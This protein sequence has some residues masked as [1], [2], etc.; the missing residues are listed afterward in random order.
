MNKPFV[1][2]LR[3]IVILMGLSLVILSTTSLTAQDKPQFDNAVG[4]LPPEAFTQPPPP[5]KIE[6]VTTDDGFD[7]FFLGLDFAEPHM[8]SNPMNPLEY[9]N[10]WNTNNSHYTYDGHDW[11]TQAPPFPGYSMRG[12]PVTAYDSLGNLY[13][14]NMYGSPSIQGAMVI[15][16]TDNGAT[17]GPPVA[18]VS[19]VDKCW[20]AC[21]QTAGP[22][23]NFVYAVMT[24]SGGG[25][26]ARSTDFGGTWQ[27]TQ[28]FATQSL[29]GM[30]VAVGPDVLGGNDIS[31]GC[32]YVVTNGGNTFAP[33]YTFYRSTDGGSTFT[34]MSSQFFA[35]YVGTN[36]SGRHSVENMRTRPYPF[37]AADNSRGPYRGRLYCVYASNT[38]V[39]NGNKPDIFVQFSDD[40]GFSWSGPILINDDPNTT[41][42]HQWS[43]SIWCDKETGRFYAKWYDS[44]N[45]PTSDSCDVYASYSD[46]GG[47][48]WTPNV[49]LTNA[50]MVIDCA[51]CPGGGTPR[52]QGDYDAITSNAYGAMAVWTDFRAGNFGSY[53]AYF[54]DFAMKIS[55]ASD[56]IGVTDSIEVVVKI[57]AVKLYEH[58]IK[59][60]V[61]SEPFGNFIYH[62]PQGDSLTAY[63]DSV[64]L[65]VQADSVMPGDY[66]IIVQAKGPNGTPVHRRTI[67]LLV[68]EPF[69]TMLQPNG[70]EELYAGTKYGIRWELALV[71]SVN[72]DYS[73]D[74][75]MTWI[76]ITS[77]LNKNDNKKPTPHPKSRLKPLSAETIESALN[78]YEWVVPTT[79]SSNCLVRVSSS[80][81]ST[82]FDISDGTFSIIP[83][84][85]PRWS[86]QDPGIDTALYS[87]SVVDTSIVWIAGANGT[88]IRSFDGGKSWTPTPLPSGE[89]IFNIFAVNQTRIFMAVN[90][91]GS[92]K[93]M[94]TF[95]G[96][97]TWQMVYENTN[98]N[99]F[100][101]AVHM[102]DILNGYALG[103]PINGQWTLL[104]TI[105]GGFSWSSAG[106]L[107]QS[108]QETGY[109]N[110]FTWI[111]DQFGWFGTDNSQ[112][113]RTT[114]GGTDWSPA[115]TSFTNSFSV[116]FAT[117]ML[118]LASGEATDQSQDGGATWTATSAQLPTVSF[119]TVAL[120]LDPPRWY[121]I[122]GSEVYKTTDQGDTFSLEISQPNTFFDIDMKIVPLNENRWLVGYA[123]GNMGTI[124]RYRE[125]LDVTIVTN[126]N[127]SK[128]PARFSLSQNY[129]NPFNPTTTISYRLPVNAEVTIHIVNV[130]GQEVR[131][132]ESG[133]KNAGSYEV[134]WDGRNSIG[135]PVASGIY[136]YHLVAKPN[137]GK[138]YSS[139]KKMMILK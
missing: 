26:F 119:G 120:D 30:M 49:R 35:N 80:V 23:A 125:L 129:P 131:L 48:T 97:S 84:P 127:E 11:E 21:D 45:V 50:R 137:S 2:V 70:G 111:G 62:F 19:G 123:V 92:A 17:W 114:N 44:R 110:A 66:D 107:A 82:F 73:L 124:S 53:T 81:D 85:L 61:N 74:S 96:G 86:V 32:V 43:P 64:L 109:N 98:A 130:L 60:S 1:T 139:F 118:G 55:T 71:D 15:R 40:Q 136:F 34:L 57:P 121:S 133:S 89:D 104:R 113:Y 29:P 102:F 38:P 138:E 91:P 88:V 117:E 5:S 67:S 72:L 4:V 126:I 112:I 134:T 75:G 108:G 63:P 95:N 12:D 94:R 135:L 128:V 47:V 20:M 42:N 25:N 106:T 100:I 83:V 13:F 31:G 116:A 115:A 16:S 33:T 76:N 101:N 8:S 46:D 18:A 41:N 79:L 132:L 69:I 36:V 51:T 122:A 52:Y 105:D 65:I 7:N 103:D 3:G 93:I 24:G 59:V 22:F 68:T 39:G 87:V 77:G 90:S 56:T 9:F 28:T 54:P 14:Q 37:I 99:A 58:G 10:A 27:T 6:T 78:R